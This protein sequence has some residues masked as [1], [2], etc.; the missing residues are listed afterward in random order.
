MKKAYFV[1]SI[2]VAF[3]FGLVAYIAMGFQV[4]IIG[5]K[6]AKILLTAT[7]FCFGFFHM[8]FYQ[9]CGAVISGYYDSKA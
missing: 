1:T 2:V 4:Y 3:C 7:I 9:I 5:I 6:I 8:A